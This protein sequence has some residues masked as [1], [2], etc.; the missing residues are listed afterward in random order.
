M[1]RSKLFLVATTGLL[2]VL[3]FISAKAHRHFVDMA[4]Y[5]SSTSTALFCTIFAN[6][7]ATTKD[8]STSQIGV[9]EY[10]KPCSGKP[11]FLGE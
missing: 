3:G 5:T 2:V 9:T 11:V 4:F 7:A 6:G 8:N 10:S 1:K